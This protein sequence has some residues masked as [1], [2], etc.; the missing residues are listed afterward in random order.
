M[1]TGL[2]QFAEYQPFT[3][4]IET[5]RA[6]LAGTPVGNNLAISRGLV[7]GD[8][9]GRLPVGQ[10]QLQQQMRKARPGAGAGLS[11][12]RVRGR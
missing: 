3:P 12:V 5:I 7:R 10:T 8:R 2:R 9:A 11:H 1:P 4:I 6:L